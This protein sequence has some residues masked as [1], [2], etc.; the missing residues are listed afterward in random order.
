MHNLSLSIAILSSYPLYLVYNLSLPPSTYYIPLSDLSIHFLKNHKKL[1]KTSPTL[2]KSL[3]LSVAIL[4]SYP[5]LSILD[6]RLRPIF[7]G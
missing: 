6:H 7:P 3:P 5:S 4:L 2:C 1:Y